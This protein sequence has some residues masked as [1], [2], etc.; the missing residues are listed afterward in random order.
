ILQRE[1]KCYEG[2][3]N[4]KS[5]MDRI[6]SEN[7]ISGVIHFAAHKAV[8]ESTQF[9]LKYYRNNIGS[10]LVLLET[11]KEFGVRDLVFSSSCTVYGQPDQLPVKESTPRKDAESPY[12]FTKRIGEDIVRDHVKSGAAVRIIALR[13]CN[14][15]GAHESALIGELPRGVPAYLVPFLTQTGV[16]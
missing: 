6:F 5:L 11:M 15:I 13:Y 16:G 7:A 1:V 14:P 10:L 4:E 9:P 3:C 8:G 12:G 2:D